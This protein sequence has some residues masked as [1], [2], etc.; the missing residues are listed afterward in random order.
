MQE[1]VQRVTQAIMAAATGQPS[2][3]RDTAT[4]AAPTLPGAASG[5]PR[6]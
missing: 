6:D 3:A 1:A 4:S 5:S 2:A